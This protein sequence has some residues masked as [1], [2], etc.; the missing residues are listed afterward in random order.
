MTDLPDIFDQLAED[1][2]LMT[3]LEQNDIAESHVIQ[4]LFM[5]G[6]IDLDDY[7]FEELDVSDED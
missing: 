7:I 2:G 4:L 5:S 1:F 3:L 6:Q